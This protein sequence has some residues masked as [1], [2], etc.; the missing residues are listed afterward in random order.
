MGPDRRGTGG[1]CSVAEEEEGSLGA[2]DGKAVNVCFG[3][4]VP[5]GRYFSPSL[6]LW[7]EPLLKSPEIFRAK[8][9]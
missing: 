4:R 6:G 5:N 8:G 7:T 9:S 3:G 1:L 2:T